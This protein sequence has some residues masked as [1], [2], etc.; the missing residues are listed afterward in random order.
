MVLGVAVGDGWGGAP[1]QAAPKK[2]EL[3]KPPV[4]KS[5]DQRM[6]LERSGAGSVTV[7]IDVANIVPGTLE[8]PAAAW[9]EVA[10]FKVESAP[11]N[12]TAVMAARGPPPSCSV[13]AC[14][15]GLGRLGQP[16]PSSS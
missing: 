16:W 7:R 5:Y 6:Q 3:P 8:L 1:A 4:I 15:T 11:A 9:G 12:V 2:A 13:S 10:D 14:R